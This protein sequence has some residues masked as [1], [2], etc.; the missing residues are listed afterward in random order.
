[1]FLCT[2][3][4]ISIES[5][6]S[7]F[8]LTNRNQQNHEPI[9]P[10]ISN[11]SLSFHYAPTKDEPNKNP[12]TLENTVPV[13]AGVPAA[14]DT[15]KTVG[16]TVPVEKVVPAA[17]DTPKTVEDTVRMEKVVPAAGDT[18]KVTQSSSTPMENSID[19]DV[20]K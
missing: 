11:L 20:S 4:P 7:T 6:P 8:T 1:M 5:F 10:I 12:G 14:G 17:G 15:P 16:G 3:I 9:F 19:R 2:N 13:E 18:S